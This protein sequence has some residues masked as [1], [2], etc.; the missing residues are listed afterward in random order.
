VLLEGVGE[1]G[2]EALG[3]LAF[4]EERFGRGSVLEVIHAGG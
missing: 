1:E 3:I 4:D 2:E